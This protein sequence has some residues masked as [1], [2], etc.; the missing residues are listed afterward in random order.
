MTD[1]SQSDS[2]LSLLDLVFKIVQATLATLA[3]Y[4][5]ARSALNAW[6]SIYTMIRGDSGEAIDESVDEAA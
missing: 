2:G 4:R 1:Q 6:K 3:V 5:S